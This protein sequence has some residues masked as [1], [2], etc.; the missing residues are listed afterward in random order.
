MVV[1]QKSLFVAFRRSL[2]EWNSKRSISGAVY[3]ILLISSI[4]FDKVFL[5]F[6]RFLLIATLEFCNLVQINKIIPSFY[7]CCSIPSFLWSFVC[8][9]YY[10]SYDLIKH[11]I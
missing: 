8:K 4:Y 5:L 6:W 9:D 11:L 2:N 3:V 7:C 1:P 10:T